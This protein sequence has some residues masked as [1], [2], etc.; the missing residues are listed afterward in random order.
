MSFLSVVF[1]FLSVFSIK[2][3]A[4]KLKIS[5]VFLAKEK[6]CSVF[7]SNDTFVST[8]PDAAI[9]FLSHLLKRDVTVFKITVNLLLKHIWSENYPKITY[10][11]SRLSRAVKLTSL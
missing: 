4:K 2:R 10:Y 6:P 5:L 11:L 7:E 3:S 9:G 1:C 8:C